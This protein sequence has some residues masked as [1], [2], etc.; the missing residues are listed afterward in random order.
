MLIQVVKKNAE[1]KCI[2][3]LEKSTTGLASRNLLQCRFSDINLRPEPDALLL[4]VKDVL[5]EKNASLFFCDDGD[6]FVRWAG[7]PKATLDPLIIQF[8]KFYKEQIP[9]HLLEV[10]F[11]YYDFQVHGEDIRLECRKK[12][13]KIL[14]THKQRKQE[15]ADR[16]Q[17]I[18]EKGVVTDFNAQLT[19]TL[20]SSL[21]ERRKRL[22]IE[23]LIVEDQLFSRKLLLGVLGQKYC[24][25]TAV[26][27]SEAIIQY[28]LHAPDIVFLD[29]ELPDIDGHTLA[30][31]FALADP[32]RYIVMVSGN[33]FTTDVGKAKINKVRGFIAKPYNK[34]SIMD[35]VNKYIQLRERG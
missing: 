21:L 12:L 26:N 9:E 28:A 8:R 11:K 14:Q 19:T 2:E 5:A 18:N 31:K 23:I 25:Y 17:R 27:A 6:V 32:D 24:C 16:E 35:A 4:I 13:M 7:H 22:G 29:I 3:A 20:N 10:F 34:Q 1:L 30:R 33:H 15:L